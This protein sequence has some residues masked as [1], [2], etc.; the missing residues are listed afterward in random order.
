MACAR[1]QACVHD[2]AHH[3]SHF[4]GPWEDA[5]LKDAGK[6]WL[7]TVA[8]CA[9]GARVLSLWRAAGCHQQRSAAHRTD[10]TRHV[11]HVRALAP[12]RN[13][14]CTCTQLLLQ[15]TPRLQ[16]DAAPRGCRRD[17]GQHGRDQQGPGAAVHGHVLGEACMACMDMACRGRQAGSTTRGPCHC[18]CM[19]K[20]VR[21]SL[22]LQRSCSTH[23]ARTRARDAAAAAPAPRCR[24]PTTA[25][26]LHGR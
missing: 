18:V 5:G 17:R 22:S 20:H 10:P 19:H 11:R 15:H 6:H 26:R 2:T 8:R 24:T 16:R 13:M 21:V 3:S 25:A 9:R 14:R 23:T 7:D 12:P 4:Q 1:T